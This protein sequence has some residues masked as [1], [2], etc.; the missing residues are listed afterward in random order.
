M[1][2]LGEISGR[3]STETFVAYLLTQGISTQID[4]AD[5]S[6]DRWEVWVRDEDRLVEAKT[7]L[8]QFQA[9]P[10]E[11]KYHGALKEASRILTEKSKQQEA[12]AKN[13]RRTQYGPG[14]VRDRRIPPLTLTLVILSCLVSLFSNF[15]GPGAERPDQ[16]RLGT[17]NEIGLSIVKQLGF[18]SWNDYQESGGDPAVNLKKGQIWRAVTPIFLHLSPM[19]LA[20][21]V[22]G[23]IALGRIAERWLGTPWFALL[24]LFAAVLPNLLQGLSPEWMRGNPLFGGISGVVYALFGYVW[25]RSN[26]NPTL[27]VRFPFPIIVLLIA[28]LVIGFSG[29]VA[30]WPYADLAHF[31]GLVV[32]AAAAMLHENV[33]R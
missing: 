28:P 18:V 30:N 23:L 19:H 25:V 32:G 4:I 15:S 27:G 9:N 7:L 24:I 3:R 16:R 5:E 31:G 14:G 13:V 29:V 6:S 33:R 1:R 22:L 17:H 8:D 10:L 26:L 21:N 20:F 12:A 11:P 2:C